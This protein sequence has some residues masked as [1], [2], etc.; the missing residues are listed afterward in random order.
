VGEGEEGLGGGQQRLLEALAVDD[1][2]EV[3]RAGLPVGVGHGGPGQADDHGG[4]DRRAGGDREPDAIAAQAPQMAQ[5]VHMGYVVHGVGQLIRP[6]G[7]IEKQVRHSRSH[8]EGSMVSKRP[9]A[10]VIGGESDMSTTA[11]RSE[12]VQGQDGIHGRLCGWIRHGCQGRA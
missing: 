9:P 4:P 8:G 5:I 2:V 6:Q 3:E 1:A 10:V 11:G 12:H 7:R